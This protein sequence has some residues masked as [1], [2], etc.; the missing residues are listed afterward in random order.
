MTLSAAR[1]YFGNG[2][3]IGG[4]RDEHH[5]AGFGEG[6]PR[7]ESCH[8]VASGELDQPGRRPCLVQQ[9]ADVVMFLRFAAERQLCS[10]S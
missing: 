9:I 4:R 5:V 8:G 7:E 6:P 1:R 3:P 10:P 2:L